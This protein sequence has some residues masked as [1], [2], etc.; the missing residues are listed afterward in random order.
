M[1]RSPVSAY[2]RLLREPQRYRFDAAVR[3]LLH[4]ARTA[5][6]AVAARF[7]SVPSFAYPPADV[8]GVRP[9]EGGRPARVSTPVMELTGTMGV[10]PRYYTEVLAQT[11][12]DRSRALHDFLDML[13]H[14]LVAKFAQAGVKYRLNRA[15]ETARLTPP[16]AALGDALPADPVAMMLLAFTGYGTAWL[17]DRV[18]AGTEPLLHYAG[19]LSMRPRSAD[20]LAALASDWLGRKVEVEQFAGTWL[21]LAPDQRTRLAQGRRAGV[22]N[23][24][25]VDAAI[26]VRAWD[27]Q[28]R[29]ILRVGP[30][31][32]A[33]FESLLPDRPALRRLVSLVR[34][35]LGFETGFA[36]NPVLA[37]GE[38]PPLAMSATADP[39][40]RLGWNTWLPAPGLGRSHDAAD[41]VFE[42]EIVEA[43]AEH[44][45][46]QGQNA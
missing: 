8:T 4:A 35:F 21:M 29:V 45:R 28:A 27:V 18:A 37:A 44:A 9:P 5:D 46:P 11:L 26:G 6:P 31:D 36:V 10:L 22:F 42:A 25:G 19:L 7:R 3:V 14:R 33:G 23:R 32:R 43:E 16:D 39:P 34:A 41:A 1:A 24:L 2:A 20:R 17:R 15:T 30:L 13:G 40:P 12:H 38:V